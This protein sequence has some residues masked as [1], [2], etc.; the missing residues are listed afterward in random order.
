MCSGTQLPVQLRSVFS[1]TCKLSLRTT[2]LLTLIPFHSDRDGLVK[3]LA[4]VRV[5]D[6]A[7]NLASKPSYGVSVLKRLFQGA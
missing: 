2:F 4:L 3:Q 5:W 7:A 6:Q 1:F